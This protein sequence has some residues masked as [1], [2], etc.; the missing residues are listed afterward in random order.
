[1]IFVA[2]GHILTSVPGGAMSPSLMKSSASY[3]DLIALPEYVVGEIVDGELWASPRP[4]PKHAQASS[5]LG[6]E[7][8]GPFHRGIQG[9]GGWWILFEPELHLGKDVLVPDLAGWRRERLPS[10]PSEAYFSVAP[11]WVCEVR[12]PSTAAFD[13]R[14]KL[15]KYGRAG[16]QHVWLVDPLNRSLE[17][18]RREGDAWVWVDYPHGDAVRIEPFDAVELDLAALFIND[19]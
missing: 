14:R 7:L 19:L 13:V 1:L 9:P 8:I 17:V 11:D 15:P 12:S 3:E 2:P 5:V 10:L 6:A 18:F 4:A 16:T